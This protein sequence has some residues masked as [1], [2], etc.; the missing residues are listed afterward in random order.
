MNKEQIIQVARDVGFE[1]ISPDD[2]LDMI[3]GV[4]GGGENIYKHLERFA[5]AI[6][7]ATKEE[8]EKICEEFAEFYGN[9]CTD[10]SKAI[11]ESK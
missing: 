1:C 7:A 10:I 8:D 9:A 5:A 11:R 3:G 6:R 2:A 4:F